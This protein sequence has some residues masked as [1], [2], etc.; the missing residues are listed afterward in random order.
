[1][2]NDLVL[3][4]CRMIPVLNSVATNLVGYERRA[5]RQR[6][7]DDGSRDPLVCL[8]TQSRQSSTPESFNSHRR[9]E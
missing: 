5:G 8:R 9:N 3:P 4:L 6:C 2:N 1:M 7:N